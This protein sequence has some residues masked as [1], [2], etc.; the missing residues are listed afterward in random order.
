MK[1][2]FLLFIAELEIVQLLR[3][4]DNAN[5]DFSFEAEFVG[6]SLAR[7]LLML[8]LTFMLL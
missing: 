3:T 6:A 5:I 4:S 7:D 1:L 8:L 2:T